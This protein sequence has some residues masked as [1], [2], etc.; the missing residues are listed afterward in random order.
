MN[1]RDII[2][3]LGLTPLS[4]EGGYFRETYRSE[5]L[6]SSAALPQ[7]YGGERSFST[8]IYYLVTPES[9]SVM[10]RIISDEV[11]HFY[12]G[13]PVEMLC[14]YPDG[15]GS[16]T[17]MGNALDCGEVFQ[18]TVPRGV[19]QGMRLVGDSGFALLGTTVAPGFEYDDYETGLRNDLVTA[20]PSYRERIIRLTRD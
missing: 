16:L 11:F 13:D 19:W 3:S 14:L 18:H 4:A 7:R 5:E 10:H 1:A 8:A 15:S 20:Y 17:V 12:T 2:E 6:I 9:F